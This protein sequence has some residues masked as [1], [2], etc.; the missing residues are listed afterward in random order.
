[1][2]QIPLNTSYNGLRYLKWYRDIH[3]LVQRLMTV[4]NY[5]DRSGVRGIY[6]YR[7]AISP[8]LVGIWGQRE[9]KKS[10]KTSTHPEALR[11]AVEVN[12]QFDERATQL[13]KQL[14]SE[15]YGD[16]RANRAIMEAAKDILM[17]E[18][19]HPQQVPTTKEEA[20]EFFKKQDAWREL[21]AETMPDIIEHHS[22]DPSGNIE[23]YVELDESNPYN[24]AYKVMNGGEGLSLVP[25]LKEATETY[26][27]INQEVK[28]R[29]PHDQKKHEQKTYRAINAVAPLD[30]P[31]TDINR[32][33]A[34]QHKDKLMQV[35]PT[36]SP[37]TLSRGMNSLSAVF[38]SAITEYELTIGNPWKG[39]TGTIRKNLD[40]ITS[41]DRE[42]KRRPM[43]SDELLAYRKH[44]SELNPQ[45]SLIGLMMIQT[46]CRT[47]EA[48]GLLVRDLKL[49]TN[50][51]H[52]QLRINKIRPLKNQNSVRDV[53]VVGELLD[54]LRDYVAGL[55]NTN[56]DAA[57]F[58]KYGHSK[59]ME[60]ISAM[61]R[62]VVNV[63]MG[64]GGDKTCVPYSTRHSM[65]DKLRA[66]RTPMEIQYAILGNG[67]RTVAE[68][69]GEG[70]PLAYLQQE[71]I[72]AE[73]LESW[74]K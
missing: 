56:P 67:K 36:W 9:V 37:D 4:T 60:N 64:L 1:M 28:Q 14:K 41:E 21:Y 35:N 10:L 20:D 22:Y 73:K 74:G 43:T 26:L 11:R 42:N 54:R 70:N 16:S 66:L 62:K 3:K 53:P 32:V 31:I 69:Y 2:P 38:N 24:Q 48:M 19:I 40:E 45:A 49:D 27:Q 61:L 55:E 5:L 17:K 65:K 63:K 57:L 18:G 58:P 47:K 44:V 33:K 7:R 68:G 23:T 29:T 6:R 34:R 39:L 25:T 72:K 15:V 30:T 50:V 8:D 59:G 71:I 46:G 52:F 51:P 12:N 13:R